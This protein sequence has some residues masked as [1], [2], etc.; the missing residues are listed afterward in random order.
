MTWPAAPGSTPLVEPIV[1]DRAL[2]QRESPFEGP[3]RSGG[4]PAGARARA[5]RCV[6]FGPQAPPEAS[7]SGGLNEVAGGT[8]SPPRDT[9]F[10]AVSENRKLRD[11]RTN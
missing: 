10:K 2:P 3:R 6:P 4:P 5:P 9:W 1:C 7:A 8:A 11:G